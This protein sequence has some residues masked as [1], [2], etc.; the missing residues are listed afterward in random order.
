MN[1]WAARIVHLS[2]IA[3]AWFLLL[4][5][6]A[7]AAEHWAFQPLRPVIVPPF[8]ADSPPLSHESRN[9]IDAFIEQHLRQSGLEPAPIA[10]SLTLVRRLYLD[11]H[12]LTPTPEQVDAFVNSSDPGSYAAL[13]EE[14]LA[15]PRYGECWGQHWL[16]V[17]RYA[18]THGF[19]VNTP[20]PY[21]W[22]Y[23]DY[24][25]RAFN[26]DK[27][28]GQFVFEQLAGDAVEENAATG[29]L[30]AA[31]V[32]LPGQIGQD[33]A[34]KRLARQ[35]ALHEMV[36]GVGE[37]FLA[38][39]IGCARCHD[40]KFDPVSQR[41]YYAMQAFFAGVDYGDRPLND[42]A[43]R[44]HAQ[45]VQ[46]LESRIGALTEKLRR[47]AKASPA[48]PRLRPQ[49]THG[50]NVERFDPVRA[51]FVRFT[52]LATQDQNR[53]EPCL[54]ELE[55]YG[56]DSEV[57]LALVDRGTKAVSS[58]D[59]LDPQRHKLPHIHDGKYGNDRS[60]ISSV[61]GGGW[62][63]LELPKVTV[64]DRIVWGRDRQGQFKDRLPIAY[65]IE[66]GLEADARTVVATADDREPF[67]APQD[68]VNALVRN[69]PSDAARSVADLV[70][71][72]QALRERKKAMTPIPLVFGGNFRAPDETRVLH[73]GDPE[74]ST[75]RVAPS[76]V[77]ILGDLA[78]G[79]DAPEQARRVALARW[80]AR[81]DNPLTARVMAN[82]VWQFH[83]GR[84]LV[85][86]PSDFGLHGSKPSHPQ[87]LDWLAAQLIAS[88]G[89]I[90]YLHRLILLSATYRQSTLAD[91]KAEALDPENRLLWRF[92]RR[93]L[94][95]EAI[96]DNL[97]WVNG[98]LNLKRDG[99]GFDF[100]KSR[101]GLDGFPPLEH[102]GPEQWRRMIYAHKV[103]ME[104]APIF[105]AFDCP[106]AGQPMPRRH[107]STTAIQALNLFNSAFVAEQ[108]EAFAARIE[109]EPGVSNAVEV[110]IDRAFLLALGRRPSSTEARAAAAAVQQYGLPTL[111]RALYNSNEFLFLP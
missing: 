49:L 30:V 96:R 64:V 105:G 61:T 34:S 57:N 20:R 84:G 53:H 19:E 81:A 5:L 98:R 62:V 79:L 80:I 106:D 85:D 14:V 10:D 13:V 92:P 65:R 101:G 87:L 1:A 111:C 74:Q 16:D 91:A 66:V 97:L 63:Q 88:G 46:R 95:A 3:L 2:V 33:E 82:R 110:R 4:P 40:H 18:D 67:G 83:F 102:M 44:Q 100:F 50:Q 58:G 89:S 6:P 25:I 78:L 52:I 73:R 24:V 107:Q 70:E 56:P 42:E 93:R 27:P 99:P 90:K 86:T 47:L 68:E 7:A 48:L 103:R 36:A 69:L 29:F 59:F 38:L 9:Q 77:P 45:D 11:M 104:P 39:T 21:A 43:A 41:D 37:T 108:S 28:Y 55:I 12:G 54:D 60:W 22:P 26:Q 94:D 35:D 8:E 17:V 71:E 15:S 51:R 31:A 75:D 76:V 109:R 23:R 32:L 72:L